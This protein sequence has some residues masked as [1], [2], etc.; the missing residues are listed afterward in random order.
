MLSSTTGIHYIEKRSS[1]VN[2]NS[3]KK[4]SGD[5]LSACSHSYAFPYAGTSGET[6]FI[7]TDLRMHS[8]L[9]LN[10][11]LLNSSQSNDFNTFELANI[12]VEK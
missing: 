3:T 11:E 9:Q 4:D 12:F 10:A 2:K 6:V 1:I 5:D 7:V 8:P